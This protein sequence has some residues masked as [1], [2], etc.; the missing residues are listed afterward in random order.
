MDELT[1]QPETLHR[2]EFGARRHLE[3]TIARMSA[4]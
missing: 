4:Q 1:S 3:G 2:L